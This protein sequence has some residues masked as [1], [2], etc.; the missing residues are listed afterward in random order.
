MRSSINEAEGPLMFE[1]GSGFWRWLAEQPAFIDVGIRMFFVLVLAPA[2][3]VSVAIVATRLEAVART[4]A[5]RFFDLDRKA[6][7]IPDIA[8]LASNDKIAVQI[9]TKQ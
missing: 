8:A 6:A 9:Q 3:L 7:A 5:V 2:T 1:T 4:I